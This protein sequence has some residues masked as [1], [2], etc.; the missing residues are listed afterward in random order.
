MTQTATQR[1]LVRTAAGFNKK[2]RHYGQPGVVTAEDLGR[3]YLREEGR[4]YYCG[5]DLDPFLATFDHLDPFERGGANTI[6]NIRLSCLTDNRQKFT[7]TEAEY[8][9]WLAL[10]RRCKGCGDP[11]K[12]RAADYRRGLG[13][14]CSRR[15][16]GRAGGQV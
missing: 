8:R 10:E 4:C 13:H 14:Y 11:F 12:P 6:A 3:I 2:A 5:A 15:C 9:D 7:M 16:S 1:R